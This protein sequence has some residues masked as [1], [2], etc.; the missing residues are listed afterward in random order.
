MYERPDLTSKKLGY[1][2]AGAIMKTSEQPV[3]GS[4]CAQGFYPIEPTGFVCVGP[5]ATRDT[6]NEIVRALTRRPNTA[7][8][9]PY[10]Y[11]LVKSISPVYAR[12]PEP[13]RPRRER[14]GSCGS[15]AQVVRRHRVG[16][17]LW[18]GDLARR[19]RRRRHSR[20]AG[21][22]PAHH[23]RGQHPVVLARRTPG[24]QLLRAGHL[25]R[26][27]RGGAHQASQWL[28]VPRLVSL[29]GT[30]LQRDHRSARGSRRS[31]A[32]DPRFRLSRLLHSR[33]DRFSLRA[34]P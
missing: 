28:R 16:R 12:L 25:A 23:R 10:M 31:T 3:K 15:L 2:R 21:A 27:V 13:R 20:Q 30:P 17:Q 22:R 8:R 5:T 9:F 7:S 1:L 19:T 4:G 11:G 33:A 26:S 32:P 14:A 29:R 34:D 18:P 24:A 6:K